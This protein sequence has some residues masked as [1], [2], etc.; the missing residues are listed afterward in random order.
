MADDFN[1]CD[2]S[3]SS[4][5]LALQLP[6]DNGQLAW[7]FDAGVMAAAGTIMPTAGRL[8]FV[9]IKLAAPASVTNIVMYVTV[10][11][12]TLTANRNFAA[13]FRPSGTLV[14]QTADQSTAW[15]T[16]TTKTMALAGGPFTLAA[17]T[18]RV[19]FW[20][21]GTTAPTFLRA[22]AFGS[23][24]LSNLGLSTPNLRAGFADTGLTTTAPATMGAQTGD[25]T[26][27]WAAL[28]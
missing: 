4:A 18:Y 14:A 23:S 2:N 3:D 21:T 13:L 27:W 12:A 25:S 16:T 24:Q 28:S 11:G 1:T 10:A 8:E 22:S 17:G 20:Y 6:A 7:T 19:G 15:T 26:L 5:A 9:A